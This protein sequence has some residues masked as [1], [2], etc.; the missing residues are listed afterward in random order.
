MSHLSPTVSLILIAIGLIGFIVNN[1]VA[2]RSQQRRSGITARQRVRS[3]ALPGTIMLLGLLLFLQP[4]IESIADRRWLA[5]ALW[6]L[7]LVASYA[8]AYYVWKR[9]H[10][11]RG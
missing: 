8:L 3:G 1:A 4:M 10:R 5:T 9:Q 7:A 6:F 2:A 11:E